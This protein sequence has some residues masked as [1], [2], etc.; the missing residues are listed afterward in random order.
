MQERSPCTIFLIAACAG[1]EVPSTGAISSVGG[2]PFILVAP[3]RAS[4]ISLCGQ[5]RLP[6]FVWVQQWH[7]CEPS[8]RA[9]LRI[10]VPLK[11][12]WA[13]D[14][15][16]TICS[17]KTTFYEPL[18]TQTGC[19]MNWSHAPASQSSSYFSRQV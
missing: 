9:Q 3:T 16:C 8:L 10:S 2:V 18:T 1:T 15:F 17:Y 5:L 19:N 12:K 11:P 4:H 6:V 7:R 13:I 14:I